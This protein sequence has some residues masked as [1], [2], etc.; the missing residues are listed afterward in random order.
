[1]DSNSIGDGVIS[2]PTGFQLV[3]TVI[4]SCSGSF[5]MHVPQAVG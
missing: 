2:V 5:A 1:M 4:S 3:S